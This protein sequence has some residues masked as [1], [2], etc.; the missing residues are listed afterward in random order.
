VAFRVEDE[1]LP[2]DAVEEQTLL[3]TAAAEDLARDAVLAQR[4][5]EAARR[6]DDEEHEQREAAAKALVDPGWAGAAIT[7]ALLDG[8]ASIDART[9]ARRVLDCIRWNSVSG[10]EPVQGLRAILRLE[11]CQFRRDEGLA[12]DL[13]VRNEAQERRSMMPILD[14]NVNTDAGTN[15]EDAQATLEIRRVD[16]GELGRLARS[17]HDVL[18]RKHREFDAIEQNRSVRKKIDLWL[19][20]WEQAE[21][22]VADPSNTCELCD[23]LE[24][25]E[26]RARV[27]YFAFSEGLVPGARDD[28]R[29][30]WVRFKV[31]PEK[32]QQDEPVAEE[33]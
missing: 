31:L 27:V 11:G 16:G 29:S 30:N 4:L 23:D 21:Q 10:G 12:F 17:A 2:D 5:R 14:M 15:W 22:A 6:L 7:R 13:E 1:K 26:Y 28:L 9:R 8:K 3:K 32:E 19:Q 18:A 25:G 24:P 33:K 20:A